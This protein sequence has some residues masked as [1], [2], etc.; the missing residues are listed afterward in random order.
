MASTTVLPARAADLLDTETRAWL[1]GKRQAAPL[2]PDFAQSRKAALGTRLEALDKKGV[3]QVTIT[4]AAT[5]TVELGADLAG[6]KCVAS[7]A[8]LDGATVTL[9]TC[10]DAGATGSATVTLSGTAGSSDV[11]VNVFYDASDA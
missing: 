9:I 7:I 3:A 11:V 1:N 6:A 10:S 2:G 8:D 4:G 5:G